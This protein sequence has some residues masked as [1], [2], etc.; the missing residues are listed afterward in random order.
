VNI[1]FRA[2]A[3]NIYQIPIPAKSWDR[4]LRFSR[5]SLIPAGRRVAAWWKVASGKRKPWITPPATE[6]VVYGRAAR[7]VTMEF[8]EKKMQREIK[9]ILEERF[10]RGTVEAERDHRDLKLRTEHQCVLIEIKAAKDARLAI[11]EAFGQLLEYAYFDPL[12]RE[13]GDHL[14][15]VGRGAPAHEVQQY[16]DYL[17]N[18]FGL[19]ITYLSYHIGTNQLDFPLS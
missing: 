4:I 17:R 16:L 1:R 19:E 9:A 15:I 6:P 14:F 3:L 10:G 18:R 5:Y 7:L 13:K 11:R 8:I 12:N 2:E